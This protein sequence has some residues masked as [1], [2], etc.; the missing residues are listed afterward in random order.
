MKE[1]V[2]VII[3]PDGMRKALVGNILSKFSEARLVMLAIGLQEV[4]LE[5]AQEH[6]KHLRQ[7]PFFNQ[8]V[9]YL[10]GEFHDGEKVLAIIFKGENAIAKCRDIAGATNPE[11]ADP[12]SIRGAFGRITTQG[13]FENVVHVSSDG[14]EAEREIKLWFSPEEVSEEIFPTKEAAAKDAIRRV[15]A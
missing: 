4:S 5:R 14:K 7:K 12:A 6:Y 9:H 3:K 10:M 2:L 11:E 1:N 15:W 13:L 8:I